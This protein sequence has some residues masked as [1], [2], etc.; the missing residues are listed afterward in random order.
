MCQRF[1]SRE[2]SLDFLM[3][4]RHGKRPVRYTTGD[5]LLLVAHPGRWSRYVLGAVERTLLDRKDHLGERDALN[6]CGRMRNLV[7]GDAA[8]VLL[9]CN[10]SVPT[11]VSMLRQGE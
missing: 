7:P 6:L 1:S 3:L 9:H 2:V 5:S 4:T 8:S 10:E 11:A